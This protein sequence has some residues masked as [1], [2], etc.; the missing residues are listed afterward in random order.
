MWRYNLID[1]LR[2][3]AIVPRYRWLR[4]FSGSGFDLAR[5]QDLRLS[6]LIRVLRENPF[7]SEIAHAIPESQRLGSPREALRRFPTQSKAEASAAFGRIHHPIAGRREQLKKTGGSTGTPFRYYLD[8]ESV[9]HTWA[10]ILWSWHEYA[11]FVPGDPFVTLAGTSLQGASGGWRARAY[12][13]LQNN[14]IIPADNIRPGIFLPCDRLA[15]AKILYAYPSALCALLE[16]RPD[17]P[18]AFRRLRAVVTTSEQLLPSVRRTLETRMGVEIFDQYGANDGGLISCETRAHDGFHYD[19][20]NCHVEPWTNEEGESELLLTNLNTW[21]FPLVRYRVG[22]LGTAEQPGE[23]PGVV[24]PRI[25]NLRG[26]TRDVLKLP[27]GRRIHGAAVNSAF[28]PVAGLKRYRIVQS[29]DHGLR[30]EIAAECDG[31]WQ[32]AAERAKAALDGLVHSEVAI[33][34]SRLEETK[35]TALK[36]KII[37]S[38]VP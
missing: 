2:G 8:A 18:A 34:V 6:E 38:H 21:T 35:P 22:D 1:R 11:G 7:Y 13:I 29:P 16:V 31:V 26:R 37:E 20:L 36:F 30:L 33:E 24:F 5:E 27:S 15:R 12:R 3:T 9:G 25:L 19:P 4:E 17:F 32:D 14:T 10:Y 28:Y 23:T